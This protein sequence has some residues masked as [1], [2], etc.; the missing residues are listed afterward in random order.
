MADLNPC[1]KCIHRDATT[2]YGETCRVHDAEMNVLPLNFT[3]LS[4]AFLAWWFG[5]GGPAKNKMWQAQDC[6]RYQLQ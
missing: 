5:S 6:P 2:R 4:V 3:A 1:G